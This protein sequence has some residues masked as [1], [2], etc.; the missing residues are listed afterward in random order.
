M[1]GMHRSPSFISKYNVKCRCHSDCENRM[2]V[3]HA[4]VKY[5]RS[6]HIM[7]NIH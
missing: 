2:E 3:S 1:C 7:Y 6:I 5:I 4:R